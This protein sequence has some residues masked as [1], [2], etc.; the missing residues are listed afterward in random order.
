[1]ACAVMR[2]STSLLAPGGK[3]TTRRIGLAGQAWACAFAGP[4]AI[5][6]KAVARIA[7]RSG[8]EGPARRNVIGHL[9]VAGAAAG[10][11]CPLLLFLPDFHATG[12]LSL[13]LQRFVARQGR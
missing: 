11:W 7:A 8:A 2:D 5:A 1:M 12:D 3:G 6:W 4:V 10:F 13:D 9:L